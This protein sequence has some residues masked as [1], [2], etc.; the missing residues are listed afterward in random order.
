MLVRMT[1]TVEVPEAAAGPGGSARHVDLGRLVI[2]APRSFAAALKDYVAHKS[3]QLPSQLVSLEEVL[4]QS[5]GGQDDAEKLKRWLYQQWREQQLR[6][7][8]LVGDATVMPVR[9]MVLD[10]ITAA[11]Y[12]YAFYPSDL[13]YADVAR[14][15]GSFDDWNQAKDGFHAQYFGEVRGEKN[16]NDPINYDAISYLP[17]LAVGRWPVASPRQAQV[18]AAKSISYENRLGSRRKPGANRALFLAIDG[19]V[20]SRPS[21]DDAA[22]QLSPGWQIAKRYYGQVPPPSEPELYRFLNEGVG[23]VV[24]AGHG[25]SDRWDQ[26]ASLGGFRQFVRNADRLPLI[27]SAGCSTAYF[28]PLPPYEA[29]VDA[30]G[31]RHAGTNRGEVF[32]SPPPPPAVYQPQQLPPGLGP[33]LVAG[34]PAGCVAYFGCNTGS[35]PCGLT[36]VSALVAGVGNG[37]PEYRLGDAWRDA[38]VRYFETERLAQLKPSDSW[39]PPSIFFQAMKFM[40]FGDPTLLLPEKKTP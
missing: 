17:E 10:R 26:V 33:Q 20:D 25:E 14:A 28:A 3:K 9:Y 5:A 22:R 7:V 30:N 15:D 36:L 11:A 18:V 31:G 39:Y 23:L 34:G 24:H 16:K 2:V 1:E 29:Y 12:D 13:Y 32:S 37:R 35:Q 8:L 6:Y 19:W 27:V 21:L 38:V 40:L 4:S